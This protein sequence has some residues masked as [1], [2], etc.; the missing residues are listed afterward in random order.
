MDLTAAFDEAHANPPSPSTTAVWR[1]AMGEE[2]PEGVDPYSWVSRSELEAIRDVVLA[3]GGRLADVGCGRG[4]PG[5]W[6]AVATGA[7]LVGVDISRTGLDACIGT[8]EALGV[9]AS[10]VLGSFEDLPLEDVSVD[11][12]MSIDAFLFS[13][14]KPAA[15]AELARVIR[16]DGRLVMT[17]WD[18]HSQPADRP[19]QIDDHRP[20][21]AAAGFEV[22][23]YDDTESWLARQRATTA[24]MIARLDEIAAEEHADPEE[25]REG[26]TSMDR[27]FDDMIRR[28][29]VVA[30]RQKG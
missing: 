9:D 7:R 17:S 14:D 4:G 19:P 16:P 6:V 10:F 18:Y 8:A 26:I 23:R 13:P 24:G 1:E 30:R 28:F 15:M 5:L 22:E 11:V 2:Y 27:T 3:T 12:V 29:L 21:L 25:L 20:L